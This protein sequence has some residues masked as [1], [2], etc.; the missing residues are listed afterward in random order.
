MQPLHALVKNGR[1]TLDEPTTLPE[2]QVVALLPFDEILALVED[3]L[4]DQAAEPGFAF[5]APPR[6][7]KRPA[8][9]D[10]RALIDELRSL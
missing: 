4:G 7:Y 9:V 2:G 1:L 10:A 8:T 6:T 5:V 3:E